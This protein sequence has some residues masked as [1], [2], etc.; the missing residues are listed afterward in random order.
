MRI[1]GDVTDYAHTL[2]VVRHL[3]KD[4][5]LEFRAPVTI[6][7]GENGTGKSTLLEAIAGAMGINPE[8]GTSTLM[9]F[10]YAQTESRLFEA[11]T[12]IRKQN[13]R[14][15]VFLRGETFFNFASEH[16]AATC[17]S[18]K[19][20]PRSH[21]Q[22][23]QQFLDVYLKQRGLFIFDEPESG[24]SGLAQLALLGQ[25]YKAASNGSQFIIATHSVILPGIPGADIYQIGRDGIAP[26]DYEEVETVAVVREFLADPYG[27]ADYVCEQDD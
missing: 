20:H 6:I 1:D 26:I 2:P 4:G 8:G 17:F 18:E 5:G 9:R 14:I 15:S 22:S 7:V 10:N 13:P 16:D 21:G 11:L 27:V 3:I 12:L 19:L 24:L 25:I 23:V